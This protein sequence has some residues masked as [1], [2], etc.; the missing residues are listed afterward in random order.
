MADFCLYERKG[1]YLMNYYERALALKEETVAHRRFFHVNAEVGLNMPKGQAYVLEELKK[2]GIDAQPCGHGVT[3]TVGKGGKCLLL[4]ADMDALPM[5]EES[6]LDFACPTGTEAHTCGHD[7]HVAMLLTAAKMLKENE[8]NLEGTVKF[9]FQP[10]EE[11][12]EGAKNMLE[13]GILENPTPDAA[14]AYH[15]TSGKMPVGIYMYNNAS[16]MMFSVDGF[17]ITVHGKGAHGAYPHSSI[18]PINIAVHIYTALEALIAREVDPAKA[19]L[20]T[21]GKFTAGTASNIIPETAELQGTIR[22]NDKPSRELL[23]R[24]MKEIAV[25]TAETYGGTA[26][27]EMLSEVPPL[28]CDPKLTNE[29]VG[30]MKDMNIPGAMPYPGISASASEDFASIADKIPGTFMYLSAGFLDD[31]GLAPAHNPKVMFNEDV[32]PI[33]ASSYAHCATEWLKNNK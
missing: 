25:K 24:R 32:C 1:C 23:V 16:T 8:A 9:M 31:R 2:L 18:D 17:K 19:N 6:G 27:I 4:R 33:G 15:V 3:A 14:L 7:F 20:L 11:T 21:I 13:N 26:K 12:F 30:Y 5:G 29:F 28:I 10:A 22:S